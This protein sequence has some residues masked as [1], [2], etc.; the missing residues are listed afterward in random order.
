[1]GPDHQDKRWAFDDFGTPCS[2]RHESVHCQRFLF[3][4]VPF[5]GHRGE[6]WHGCTEKFASP[7]DEWDDIRGK[8]C[9]PQAKVNAK[10]VYHERKNDLL[11]N[12]EK[13]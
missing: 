1:M 8:F 2:V 6:P 3:S 13:Y 10:L 12:R 9:G 7:A 4:V 11:E 5:S